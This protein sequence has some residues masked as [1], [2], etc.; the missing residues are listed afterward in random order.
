MFNPLSFL[1]LKGSTSDDKN[2]M[3]MSLRKELQ[4]S[5]SE[6]ERV[7]SDP[8]LLSSIK[9]VKSFQKERLTKTHQQFLNN[10]DTNQAAQFFLNELYGE[11]DFSIY[12]KDL[13]KLLPTMEK[14]FPVSALNII[15]KALSLNLLTEKL[16]NQ[17]AEQLGSNFTEKQYWKSY[18]DIGTVEDRT[19]QLDLLKDIGQNLIKASKMP[20]ISQLLSVMSIPAQQMDLMNL[21]NFLKNGF[22]VFKNTKNP[23]FFIDTIYSYE[24]D[25]LKSNKK[26]ILI[27]KRKLS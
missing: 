26:P 11:K 22:H 23:Q 13:D 7:H 14:M 25:I 6:Y 1:K 9:A 5:K 20:L 12:Y 10:P 17:L 18:N 16:D 21:H 27:K 4:D 19:F 15:T 2:E 8:I 24:M 3:I